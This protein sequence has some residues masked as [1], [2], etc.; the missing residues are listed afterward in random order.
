MLQWFL[1]LDRDDKLE[2]LLHLIMYKLTLVNM[3]F[4]SQDRNL[5]RCFSVRIKYKIT[6]DFTF[7]LISSDLKTGHL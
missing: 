4:H 3:H 5:L 2:L 7:T 6:L 1:C